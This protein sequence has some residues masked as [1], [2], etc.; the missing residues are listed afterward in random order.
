MKVV[1]VFRKERFRKVRRYWSYIYFF[2]KKRFW[3]KGRI[4]KGGEIKREE[5]EKEERRDEGS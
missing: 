4:E 2:L 1:K 5:L 3:W